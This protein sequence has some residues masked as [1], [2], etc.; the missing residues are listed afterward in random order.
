MQTCVDVTDRRIINIACEGLPREAEKLFLNNTIRSNATSIASYVIACKS[1]INPTVEYTMLNIRVLS[2]L[3]N[4]DF[5][6]GANKL[7][8]QTMEREHIL[9]Y[10]DSLRK[11]EL[12][13]P[14]H[15][16][17]GT[18]NLYAII[19]TKFFKW[20]YYPDIESTKRQK[21]ACV[22]N[23][24]QLKRKENSIYKP[25]DLWTQEDDLLFLRFC[26][27]KRD[28]CYHA[29]SRDT[30]CRPHEILKLKIKDIVFKMVYNRQYAE[31]LVNGK[32]GSRHIPLIDSIPYVKDWLDNHPQ[33]GNPNAALICGFTRSLGRR[34]A[35]NSLHRV[36]YLYRNRLFPR[37]LHDAS[38]LPEDKIRIKELLK[39]PWNP[40]IRRHSALTQKSKLLKEHVLRQHAGWSTGSNMPQKYLHYFGNESS[41][42]LLE[43]YGLK[44]KAEEIDKL[45]PKLCPN[46]N[47]LNK[48]ESKF[49]AKCRMV[50]S[51]DAYTETV[52]QN[53]KQADRLS[54]MEEQLQQIF[55]RLNEIQDPKKHTEF[56]EQLY[57]SG[58]I[59][60][61]RQKNN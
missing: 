34:I 16:W 35:T 46:C 42:S 58:L 11:P 1:E 47:E 6:I 30:S 22:Q 18:Y 57:K 41:E 40:Y 49:C 59:Q 20:L 21:P 61:E 14:L 50:L 45:K 52:E 2:Y 55:N 32:T 54:K 17:I 4:F 26:P 5:D 19:I 37:L 3:S 7:K 13:D 10:L 43:A 25:T 9:A 56:A 29:M 31:I 33:G 27:S 44:P 28:R 38:V 36:Y 53:G 60:I 24:S 15:K 48:I 39:K 51:Y 8:F 12:S 23:I